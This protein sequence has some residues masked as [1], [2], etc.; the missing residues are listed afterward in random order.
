MNKMD[1][2]NEYTDFSVVETMR[3]YIIP[4]DMPEG[5]YGAP[6]GKDEP[7]ENKSTPWEEGQRPYSS[8]NYEFKSLHQNL[9]RQFPG[10]HPPHDEP[11]KN[12]EDPY[13][14]K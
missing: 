2:Q 8:F 6:R 7:V 3:N 4:E 14:I 5:A 1:K 10:S 9:P 12:E 11:D 13:E